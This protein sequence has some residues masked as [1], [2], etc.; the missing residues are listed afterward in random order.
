MKQPNPT[1]GP[2]GVLITQGRK[3]LN[4]HKT[5]LADKAQVDPGVLYNIELGHTRTLR[6]GTLEALSQALEMPLEKLVKANAASAPRMVLPSGEPEAVE[7][8]EPVF[9]E[10]PEEPEEPEASGEQVRF[11]ITFEGSMPREVSDVL[12]ALTDFLRA[13]KDPG[14]SRE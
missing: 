14:G 10:E 9:H 3:R 1:P 12:R 8:E 2:L 4:L 7:L 11:T 6:R 5:S 13:R